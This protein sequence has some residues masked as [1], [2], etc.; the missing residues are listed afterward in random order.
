MW[1]IIEGHQIQ[2]EVDVDNYSRAS[3]NK[4]SAPVTTKLQLDMTRECNKFIYIGIE[5]HIYLPRIFS[6]LFWET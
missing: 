6:D 4:I 5:P 1:T 3:N 2:I